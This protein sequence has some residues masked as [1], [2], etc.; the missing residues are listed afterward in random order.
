MKALKQFKSYHKLKCKT[1]KK[2]ENSQVAGSPYYDEK[3][4]FKIKGKEKIKRN[5]K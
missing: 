3:E 5:L 1:S 4:F 2:K